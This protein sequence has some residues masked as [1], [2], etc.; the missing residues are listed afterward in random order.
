M[1]WLIVVFLV[2]AL[3]ISL[4]GFGSVFSYSWEAA[5]ILSLVLAMLSFLVS[6]SRRQA[7]VG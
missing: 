4:F 2:I 5:R 6:G 7:F 3:I 1:Q